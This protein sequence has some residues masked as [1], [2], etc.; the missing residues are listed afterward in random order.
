MNL[1]EIYAKFKLD[2]GNFKASVGDVTTGLKNIETNAKAST[3]PVNNLGSSIQSLAL[4]AAA[5]IGIYK[6]ADGMVA[7]IKESTMLAARV[8]T[9]GVVMGT[10]GK[11]VGLN[12]TQMENYAKGVASMGITTQVSSET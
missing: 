3:Q 11:N 5:A 1:G 7:L 8:E 6:L 4:K 9:L 12:A 10:V 2:T